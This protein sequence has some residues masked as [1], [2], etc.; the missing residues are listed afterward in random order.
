MASRARHTPQ[1]KWITG[2]RFDKNQ[3]GDAFPTRH[4][5]DRVAAEHPVALSSRDGHSL[6]VNSRALRACRITAKTPAPP[7]GEIVRDNRGRPTGILLE[8]A[9]SLVYSSHA[10]SRPEADE[11]ALRSALRYLAR[12]GVTSIHAMD[13]I[14]V[15]LQL[16]KL[17]EARRLDQRVTIYP[18]FFSGEYKCIYIDVKS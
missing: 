17:R 18:P 10:F 14:P 13:G 4:D 6:W 2:G 1:G 8:A 7:G 12:R 15:L 3:W 5:L 16:Q 11:E 9:T